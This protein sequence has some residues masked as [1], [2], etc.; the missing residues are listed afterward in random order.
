MS[1][2]ITVIL[3]G[4]ALLIAAVVLLTASP[5]LSRRLTAWVGGIAAIGGLIMYG[6]GYM[7]TV[8]SLPEAVIRTV[9]TVCRMFIGEVDFPDISD[10]VLFRNPWT[11]ILF[12]CF[13][14]MAFYATSS[15]TISLIASKILRKI[16]LYLN[17]RK[18]ISILFGVNPDSV[19]FGQALRKTDNCFV[20]FADENA[21][22]DLAA[23][24]GAMD[25]VLRTDPN[26]ASGNVRF[27]RSTGIRKGKRSVTV[28]ALDKNHRKNL[29]YAQRFLEA[30]LKLGLA[31]QQLALVA[32]APE[33]DA[34]RTLQVSP[35]HP[36]YGF[37][38]AFQEHW[39]AARL[40]VRNYPPCRYVSFDKTG[41]VRSGFSAIVV[42][43][44]RLG[45]AVL[46]NL[47]MNGQ[48]VGGTFRAA[49]FAPD[50]RQATGN[51]VNC[52]QGVLDHYD[53]RFHPYDGRSPE[54]YDYIRSNRE[55]LKYIV[56]CTGSRELDAQI[57]E[58]LRPF[59]NQLGL[60][61]P[62]FQCSEQGIIFAPL[63]STEIFEHPIFTP[64]ILSMKTLDRM[65]MLV[66]QQYQGENSR[67]AL[68]DWMDCDYFSR[69][70]CRAFADSIDAILCAA[71]KTRQE[72][73]GAAWHFTSEHLETL[74]Q[75]E[76]MR[77]CAFHF[78]MGFLP[79]SRQ[80]YSDRMQTYLAQV[81]ENGSASIR[82]G[83]N[84]AGKTHACLVSWDELDLLSQAESQY[85]NKPIDYKAKDSENVLMIPAMLKA[86]DKTESRL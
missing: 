6:Y 42:G 12:W 86:A 79:M 17:R 66:N 40:L 44:D 81:R 72:A 35:E 18:P 2:Y 75:M 30:S 13:H 80:E 54:M 15:L 31:S 25:C 76:H 23:Q 16:R 43:F 1:S 11:S 63:N 82:V 27:L 4:S 37:V 83:K 74:S 22:D 53:I 69:M 38:T 5:A 47:V 77:W 26:A 78:C 50:C 52:Y 48:F 34:I 39:L 55:E 62:V 3:F 85:M 49:V 41:T 73:T 29:R 64:D 67:G 71:G 65:A 84:M 57:S 9:L 61:V 10:S 59:L 60:S 46:R 32:F 70:S 56:L 36:G 19:A 45:Q 8:E 33:D 51:F 14:L 21:D 28:Y 24:I 20:V 58:E 7:T 68:Q